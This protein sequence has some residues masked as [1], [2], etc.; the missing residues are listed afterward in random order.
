MCLCA[1]D[2]ICS[3]ECFIYLT[4][5][6]LDSLCVLLDVKH[7][8]LNTSGCLS[9]DRCLVGTKLEYSCSDG[10]TVAMPSTQCLPNHTWSHMPTCVQSEG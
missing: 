4:P 2:C 6:I 9:L 5:L 3:A 1:K 8:L 10:Y 7:G